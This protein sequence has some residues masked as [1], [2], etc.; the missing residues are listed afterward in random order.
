[1]KYLAKHCSTTIVNFP[2]HNRLT[3][4]TSTEIVTKSIA[5]DQSGRKNADRIRHN[6]TTTATIRIHLAEPSIVECRLCFVDGENSQASP[7]KWIPQ[8]SHRMSCIK[9]RLPHFGHRTRASAF[10]DSRCSSNFN[11]GGSSFILIPQS[12][13]A[14]SEPTA[15]SKADEAKSWRRHT[16]LH[17]NIQKAACDVAKRTDNQGGQYNGRKLVDWPIRFKFAGSKIELFFVD[18]PS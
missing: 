2:I 1:M 17:K 3:R 16:K 10:A 8:C 4:I 12:R 13:L 18:R 11:I 5:A 6:K 14:P 15:R 7:S 9:M